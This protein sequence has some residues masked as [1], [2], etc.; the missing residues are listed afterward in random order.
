ME[1]DGYLVRVTDPN[2]R[3]KYR[4]E[5]TAKAN[6]ELDEVIG[7]MK[8]RNKQMFQGLT[9]E[10]FQEIIRIHEQVCHNLEAM[11]KEDADDQA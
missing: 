7:K 8:K 10:D 11:I 5:L 4:L 1:R 9:D 6:Q 2:D 3:R